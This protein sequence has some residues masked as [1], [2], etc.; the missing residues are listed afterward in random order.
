LLFRLCP[1]KAGYL[2]L[3]GLWGLLHPWKTSGR[4]GIASWVEEA[5]AW[6]ALDL[7]GVF[8]VVVL[9]KGLEKHLQVAQMFGLSSVIH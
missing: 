6:K 2:H 9:E 4:Q 3:G 5:L 7:R 8:G 1:W